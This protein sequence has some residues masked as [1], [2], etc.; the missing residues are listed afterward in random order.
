MILFFF[1]TDKNLTASLFWVF[2]KKETFAC[3]IFSKIFISRRACLHRRDRPGLIENHC[4]WLFVIVFVIVCYRLNPGRQSCMFKVNNRNTR[5][6]CEI[7]SKLTKKIPE[8]CQWRDS[9]VFFVNSEHIPH[10]ALV[11][12]LFT[13]SR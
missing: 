8:Q 2:R 7:C 13:L 12:L 1:M 6:R 4:I 11:F 3:T 9:S 5:A 10:L